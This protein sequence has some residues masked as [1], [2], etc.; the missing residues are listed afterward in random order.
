LRPSEDYYWVHFNPSSPHL[1][2]NSTHLD[3]TS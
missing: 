2:P 3:I 1:I